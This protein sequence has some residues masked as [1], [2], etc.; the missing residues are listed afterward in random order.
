M[1]GGKETPRQKMIGMMYLVLLG[2][3]ALQVSNTVLEKFI[4]INQSLENTAQ[5]TDVNNAN[6]V[7]RISKQVD[8]AGN[9]AADVKVLK[10]AQEVREET[11]KVIAEMQSLKDELVEMTGGMD[12]EH[13][14][15]PKNVSDEETMAN[16]M[17]NQ[18]RGNE[19]QERLNAYSLFLEEKTGV[20]TSPIALD[21]KDNPVFANNPDQRNKS[22]AELNFGHTPLVAGLATITQFETEVLMRE[23][24]ALDKLAR[25]VGAQ[26][27]KFDRIMP[28]V[29]PEAKIV[30]AGTKY[31]ADLFIAA[32]SSGVTPDMYVDGKKIPVNN[33]LGQV[34]F[35]ASPGNY[36]E[37]GLARKTYESKITVA[38]PGGKDTTYTE[39]QEY[40][41]AKPVIQIQSASVQALYLQ[42]GNDLN[43]QVP[44]LGTSYNPDFRAEGGAVYKGN[45]PGLV[46]IVPNSA[47]VTLNVSNAGTPIG[48]EKFRVRR[49][50]NPEIVPY[51]GNKEVDQKTGVPAS[52]VRSLTMRAIADE[53][54]KEFL[55]NDANFR[56]SEYTVY[57]ARGNRPVDQVKANGPD[58]DLR[59]FANQ[60]KPGDRLVIEVTKVQ[61]MNFKKEVI[62][63]PMGTKHFN[64]QLN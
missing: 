36:N 30:A 1:A 22:F 21:A 58:V 56:V 23:S 14:N 53:S 34:E 7:S 3:L 31:K 17:I 25:D 24:D 19:L 37:E 29:R 54:F 9:R 63:V 28:M 11:K 44:A 61:R 64:V 40:F 35:M 18:K 55:P 2:M 50:P 42:C 51:S 15:T 4:F 59:R 52:S 5:E 60:A 10:T 27:M 45:K 41:V 47:N 8:D 6:T 20:P 26:D 16:Y 13:P 43:V 12:P 33:G 48:A 49:V 39:V 57:L 38:L 32:S 62:D 46:T